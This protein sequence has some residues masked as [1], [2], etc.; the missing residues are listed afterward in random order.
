M[1]VGNI[2]VDKLGKNS[3]EASQVIHESKDEKDKSVSSYL[4]EKA[5]KDDPDVKPLLNLSANP[6]TNKNKNDNSSLKVGEVLQSNLSRFMTS[7]R[8]K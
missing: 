7:S 1:M 3:K 2:L 8:L 6:N 5:L 4:S